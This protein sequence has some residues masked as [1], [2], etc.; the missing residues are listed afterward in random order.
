M[1]YIK[2]NDGRREALQRGEPALTAGELNYQ[3]FYYVKHYGNPFEGRSVTL[4][5]DIKTF[6]DQFLG[7]NPN[8]QKYND[9]AGCLVL[10]VKEIKRRLK[11]DLKD[12]FKEI[13]DSYDEEIANYEDKKIIDNS[14]V[15]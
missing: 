6:V 7:G 13:V 5:K 10:C 3:I 15:E 11:I 12:L 8:Y 2:S 14:D 4:E 1:P 9:M